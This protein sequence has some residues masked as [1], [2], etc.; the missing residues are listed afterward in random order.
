MPEVELSS[1]TIDYEDTGGSGPVVVLLQLI[2]RLDLLV[3][4]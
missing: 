1:G 2:E 3:S 4:R